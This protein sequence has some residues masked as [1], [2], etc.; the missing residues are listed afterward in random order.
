M[1]KPGTNRVLSLYRR[2]AGLPLGRRVF[3]F[4][5]CRRAPY[6]ATIRPRFEQL[7]P[8]LAVVRM[9]KRRAVENHIRSVHAL[10][11]GNLCELA[12]GTMMEVSVPPGMRWI[13]RGM[14]IEY[15]KPARSNIRAEAR[16][17][18]ERW[19][20]KEDVPVPVVVYDRAGEE[21]VRACITMHVSPRPGAGN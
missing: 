18:K 20:G 6:F 19:P 16:L 21:V 3:G 5:V 11:M 13:P 4:L 12:A 8:G 2:L 1:D 17:A 14:T 7:E 9:R 15:L 10:A